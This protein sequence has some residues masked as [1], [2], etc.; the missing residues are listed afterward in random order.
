MGDLGLKR[1]GSKSTSCLRRK[2]TFLPLFLVKEGGM[3]E[4]GI[5]GLCTGY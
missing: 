5:G 2:C 3:E 4:D 1:R